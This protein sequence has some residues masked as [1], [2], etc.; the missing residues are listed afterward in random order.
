MAITRPMPKPE[1]LHVTV[2][3]T[4]GEEFKFERVIESVTSEGIYSVVYAD[5]KKG[6]RFPLASIRYIT[7]EFKES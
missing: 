5:K 2:E 6:K 4:W 3:T 7:E 1:Y